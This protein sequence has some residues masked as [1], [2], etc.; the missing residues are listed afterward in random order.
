MDASIRHRPDAPRFE[1]VRDGGPVGE[2]VYR[3]GG[4]VM[5]I[6]H[7]EVDPA[8]EGQGIGAALV[9]AALEHARSEGLKVA[10]SCPYAD[11]YMQR[12]P[13]SESLRA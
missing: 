7:T 12:H 4:G 13:D 11:S 5:S 10:P 3:L 9:Q 6:A 8:L 2:L 1:S